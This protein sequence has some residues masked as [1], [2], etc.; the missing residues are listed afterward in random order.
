MAVAAAAA[1][2]FA[3][4]LIDCVLDMRHPGMFYGRSTSDTRDLLLWEARE[5]LYL[6]AIY[7]LGINNNTFG[8]AGIGD[9]I[10][11]L[12]ACFEIVIRP[13]LRRTFFYDLTYYIYPSFEMKLKCFVRPNGKNC[14]T[15]GCG[16][17]VCVLIL[18]LTLWSRGG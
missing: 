18:C 2:L 12:L 14:A 3:H 9:A 10:V 11:C 8:C 5:C 6:W 4:S 15:D 1:R 13:T 17:C 16:V 7:F